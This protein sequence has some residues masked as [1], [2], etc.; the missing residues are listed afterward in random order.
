M[1]LW[2]LG[3]YSEG[4]GGHGGWHMHTRGRGDTGGRGDSVRHSPTG[5]GNVVSTDVDVGGRHC[6]GPGGCGLMPCQRYTRLSHSH[7]QGLCSSVHCLLFSWSLV[8]HKHRYNAFQ[9]H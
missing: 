2:L 8:R 3:L 6:C 4:Q 5:T 1:V 7:T 9:N